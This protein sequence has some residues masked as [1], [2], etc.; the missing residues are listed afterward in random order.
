MAYLDWHVGMKVVCVDAVLPGKHH[1]PLLKG[2]VYTIRSFWVHPTTGAIGITLM[3]IV[4]DIHPGYQMERGYA[5]RRFRPVETR[6]TDISVF[7][8]MLHGTDRKVDA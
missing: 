7:T 4:N 2:S 3:E 1:K 6:K 5:P 8:A